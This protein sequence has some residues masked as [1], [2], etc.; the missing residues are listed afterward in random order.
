M[1]NQYFENIQIKKKMWSMWSSKWTQLWQYWIIWFI[2]IPEYC[3]DHILSKNNE[4]LTVKSSSSS[5]VCVSGTHKIP[6]KNEQRSKEKARFYTLFE[7]SNFCP[8]IKFWQN[9][10]IFTS[11]SPKFFMTI[12]LVKSKFLDKKWRFRT[13][14][15]S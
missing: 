15:T 6:Q 12:F 1:K 5:R 11:F 7:K 8:K 10:N 13:V 9:P 2:C 4:H 3:L 14:W